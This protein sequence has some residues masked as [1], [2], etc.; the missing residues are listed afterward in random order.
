MVSLIDVTNRLNVCNG[1][2]NII[3][4]SKYG[5]VLLRDIFQFYVRNRCTK[6]KMMLIPI[7][8]HTHLYVK[9]I[10]YRL[11]EL[12]MKMERAKVFG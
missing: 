9:I 3:L 11:K 10:T 1:I 6:I 2:K 7:S 4:I 8:L 12:G 5:S